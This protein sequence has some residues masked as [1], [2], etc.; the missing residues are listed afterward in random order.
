MPFNNMNFDTFMILVDKN[1]K[2]MVGLASGD[3]PD[4]MYWDAWNEGQTPQE[5][6]FDVLESNGYA[7]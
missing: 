1:L 6:A 3:L 2:R 7:C 4:H 5:C